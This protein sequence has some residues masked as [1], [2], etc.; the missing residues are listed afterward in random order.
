MDGCFVNYITHIKYSP[1]RK[2]VASWDIGQ[3]A[4]F[5]REEEVLDIIMT[6]SFK[7]IDRK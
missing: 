3:D 4:N 2:L 7:F 6:D 1:E 5:V